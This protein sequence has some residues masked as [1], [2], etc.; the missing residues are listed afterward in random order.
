MVFCYARFAQVGEGDEHLPQGVPLELV[1]RAVAT[2][3]RLGPLVAGQ[4]QAALDVVLF[5]GQAVDR[6]NAARVVG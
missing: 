3:N 6:V 4:G 2:T 1:A 5:A